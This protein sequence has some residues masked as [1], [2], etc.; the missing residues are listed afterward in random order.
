VL[1]SSRACG[2]LAALLL[3]PTVAAAEEDA[4]YEF[5]SR[6]ARLHGEYG[7]WGEAVERMEAACATPE[8]GADPDCWRQLASIAERDGRIGL[9][10]DAWMHAAALGDRQA[11]R[12]AARLAD[13]YGRAVFALPD[14]RGLPTEPAVLEFKG[15][16]LDPTVKAYLARLQEEIGRAGLER[17][18]LW[19]PAGDYALGALA[20]SVVAGQDTSVPLPASV[21]PWRH[22][23][24]GL[25]GRTA[26]GVAGPFELGGDVHASFGGSPDGSLGWEPAALGGQLRVG[27]HA[28]PMRLELRARAEGWPSTSAHAPGGERDG[29]GLVLLGQLDVGIDLMLAPRAFLTPHAGIVG[30]SLGSA[31][32]ACV[33]E[34]SGAVV[35]AG[36]CRLGAAGVGGQAGVDAWFL[37]PSPGGRL[38]LRVGLSA[39]AGAGGLLAA[40]GIDLEGGGDL[41]LLRLDSPRF[42]WI[43]GGVDAG[44]SLRF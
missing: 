33:A 22:R 30:G 32:V 29:A 15:L 18:E 38:S 21:V 31:L 26:A 40:P 17:A 44:V 37:P 10:R 2:L 13:A 39:E 4:S 3:W 41:A 23:A 5:L 16:V 11:G 7:Q 6:Q 24:F 36:E 12:E 19:L 8:G 25:D 43:R 27:V 14:G 35:L 28:G 9:A 34:R 42:A 1:P 20:W